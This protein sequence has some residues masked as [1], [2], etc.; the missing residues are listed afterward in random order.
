MRKMSIRQMKESQVIR[1][2]VWK[3]RAKTGYICGQLV[4][5]SDGV[6]GVLLNNGEYIDVPEHD[7]SVIE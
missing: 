3:D 7:L 2:R 5:S 4:G 1:V 6:C